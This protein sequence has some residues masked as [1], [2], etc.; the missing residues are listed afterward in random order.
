MFRP[1]RF[2]RTDHY[3]G[4]ALARSRFGP[5]R[6]ASERIHFIDRAATPPF[7]GGGKLIAKGPVKKAGHAARKLT[8]S[9]A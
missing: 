5:G 6:A 9:D 4:F 1:A 3:Q 2:C 7:Q 8:R